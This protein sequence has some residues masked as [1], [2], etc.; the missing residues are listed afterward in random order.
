MKDWIEKPV[1]W[2][3]PYWGPWT[4]EDGFFIW[5]IEW[6]FFCID[7]MTSFFHLLPS[8]KVFS[9]FT[10]LKQN[11]K[12][13]RNKKFLFSEDRLS[14]LEMDLLQ[15]GFYFTKR[16]KKRKFASLSIN[17]CNQ[18]T[19]LFFNIKVNWLKK[20]A[21]FRTS[22]NLIWNL[23]FQNCV[24]KRIRY[25]FSNLILL[26]YFSFPS[27]THKGIFIFLSLLLMTGN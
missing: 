4:F 10:K 22:T 20:S 2:L 5:L 7:L 19:W 11:I 27:N 23:V 16:K 8:K 6:T 1:V 24:A 3:N 18:T 17:W 21:I 14:N 13:Q 9:R 26:L 15:F 25:F 12:K